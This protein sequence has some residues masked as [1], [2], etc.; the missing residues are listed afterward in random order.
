MP[1]RITT[2]IFFAII[3]TLYFWEHL[4]KSWGMLLVLILVPAFLILSVVLLRQCL[5]LIR[6]KFSNRPRIIT[7]VIASVALG[8]T[9]F[10]PGGLINYDKWEGTDWL[11]AQREG[12]ANCMT[13]FRLKTNSKFTEE[14][15]CFGVDRKKGTYE[16][17]NDTIYLFYKQ[18]QA[19]NYRFGIIKPD[20]LGT[21]INQKGQLH[22]FIKKDDPYPLWLK[23]T[24]YDGKK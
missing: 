13:T 21:T 2:L 9:A 20:T 3:N 12:A 16:I 23:I 8:L 18:Q 17:R 15:V 1:L 7:V 19:D 4:L 14:S 5:L 11:V 10:F 22:V 24:A 6:E